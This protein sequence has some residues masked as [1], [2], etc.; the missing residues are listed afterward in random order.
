MIRESNFKIAVTEAGERLKVGIQLGTFLEEIAEVEN[1]I[2]KLYMKGAS[3]GSSRITNEQL[4]PSYTAAWDSI[5]KMNA[6]S[7]GPNHSMLSNTISHN[8]CKL[9]PDHTKLAKKKLQSLLL[10]ITGLSDNLKKAVKAYNRN[11]EQYHAMIQEAEDLIQSKNSE[12]SA[13]VAIAAAAV[14]TAAAGAIASS[15]TPNTLQNDNHHQIEDINKSFRNFVA[16]IN[17]PN[18]KPL[19]ERCQ[20][21][22]RDI[23]TTESQLAANAGRLQETR[24]EL[25]QEIAVAF[26][27][28]ADIETSR[29]HLMKNAL[30]LLAMAENC[31]VEDTGV[32]LSAL[33]EHLISVD[34]DRD[35]LNVLQL[36][37]GIASGSVSNGS[38]VVVR[39]QE[40]EGRRVVAERS[41][42]QKSYLVKNS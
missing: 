40:G 19:T 7:I 9:F 27:E 28:L 34:S 18:D 10:R 26:Q 1:T 39:E 31:F 12:Q 29:L 13:A 35:M 33:M 36:C 37:S 16:K 25:S 20:D 3:N 30:S 4:F 42:N 21:S 38:L 32:A 2:G 24:K 6:K 15:D 11:V 17:K 41:V 23:S 14:A 22:L 5:N 8:V